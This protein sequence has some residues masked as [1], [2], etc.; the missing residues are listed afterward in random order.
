MQRFWFILVW[1]SMSL[2]ILGGLTLAY[3]KNQAAQASD[4]VPNPISQSFKVYLPDQEAPIVQRPT[5]PHLA[6][7]LSQQIRRYNEHLVQQWQ[8]TLRLW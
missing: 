3:S 4:S 7:A 2:A 1:I 6:S 8:Q 5:S